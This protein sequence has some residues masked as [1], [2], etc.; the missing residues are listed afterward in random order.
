MAILGIPTKTNKGMRNNNEKTVHYRNKN[1]SNPD[2]VE[3]L[4]RYV[5]RT[6]EKESRGN[7]LLAYG[8][9][10][11]D[12]FHSSDVMV[13]QF[14]YVQNVYGI[15]SRHGRRMYH[16]VLN[17]KDW[18]A[19]RLDC[20]LE[21][22]WRVGMECCKVY[23]MMGHQAVFAVHWEAEKRCHI[24]F[25]VNSINFR[26]GRK[27]HSSLAEIKQREMVFNDIL[28]KY[29]IMATGAIEPLEFLD[30]ENEAGCL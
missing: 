7:D 4:I 20:A 6:R 19:E 25:A 26:D 16:E 13:R 21:W 17:L 18:E 14:E 1:Y 15:K 27:W 24:H 12:Y 28:R 23:Y 11:T 3:N 22:L 8:A 30:K 2:A 10:G 5:T 29:Q 9:V